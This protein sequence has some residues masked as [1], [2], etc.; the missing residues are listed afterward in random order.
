MADQKLNGL[1][2]GL[3]VVQKF[4][5]GKEAWGPREIA[6]ELGLSKST[7]LRILQT[8]ADAGFLAL[9]EKEGKYRVGPELWRLGVGLRGHVNLATIIIPTLERYAEEADETMFFFTYNRGHVFFEAL[10]ECNHD[11][12][13][14]M[15]LGVPY[16][17]R[18]GTAGKTALAF[19]PREE[20]D[21]I[22]KKLKDDPNVD[23]EDLEK[24]V[25]HVDTVGYAF[26]RGERVKGIIG[27][28]AP[29]L[30]PGKVFLGGVGVGIPE[31]RYKEEDHE[32]YASLVKSC[33][34]EV[35]F[36]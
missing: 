9:N 29:I 16:D 4:V 25:K 7:A 36:T 28:S 11:L 35:S 3:Q 30:G 27:F 18:S 12:R 26:T 17:L 32:K 8:L 21:E 15:K 6:R 1:S 10:A 19:L 22:F 33:A 13:F 31:A 24:Q 23:L 34:R 2:K 20:R 5:F 14:H